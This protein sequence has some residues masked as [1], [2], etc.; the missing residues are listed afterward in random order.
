MAYYEIKKCPNCN[1][2]NVKNFEIIRDDSGHSTFI[3]N[4]CGKRY[5]LED[6]LASS[7]DICEVIPDE[8]DIARMEEENKE[9]DYTES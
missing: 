8:D 1:S 5:D 3:C 6:I 2:T 7:S 9:T 4:D